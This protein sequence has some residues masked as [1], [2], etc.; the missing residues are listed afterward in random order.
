MYQFTLFETKEGG[1]CLFL[2]V[3][4]WVWFGTL[5]RGSLYLGSSTSVFI[6]TGAVAVSTLL[7]MRNKSVY[8]YR[9]KIHGLEFLELL[10]S[11]FCILL[12]VEAFSLQKVVEMLEEEAV[13][14]LKVSWKWQMSQKLWPNLFNF[15]SVACV[16]CSAV[17]HCLEEELGPFC[18]PMSAEGITVLGT[19]Y[20][21]AEHTSRM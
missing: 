7:P 4:K 2:L 21:F 1:C 15:W 5:N 12:V 18:W 11:V 6:R 9:L 3:Q 10:E 8:S 16:T 20:Q 14:S 19:S 13:S 17:R